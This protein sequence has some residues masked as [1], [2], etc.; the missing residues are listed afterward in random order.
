M[1]AG[2]DGQRAAGDDGAVDRPIPIGSVLEATFPDPAGGP[3]AIVRER[4]GV[5]DR[6]ISMRSPSLSGVEAG[7]PYAISL[8]LLDRQSGEP[9]WSEEIEVTSNVNGSVVPDRPLT[10]GPGYHQPPG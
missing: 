10:I 3:P 8:R 6:R 2:A 9:I 1:V 5:P 4:I 7:V